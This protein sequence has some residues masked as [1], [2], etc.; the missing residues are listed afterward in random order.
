LEELN[1]YT[2]KDF[3]IKGHKTIIKSP[4][5]INECVEAF[6]IPPMN[7][8]DYAKCVIFANLLTW[9]QLHS[10][11]REKGGAY[12]AGASPNESGL[13]ML[14]SFRDPNPKRTFNCFEKSIIKISKGE[15]TEDDIRDAKIFTFQQTDKIINPLNKGL[16]SFLR[17]ITDEDRNIYRQKLLNVTREVKFNI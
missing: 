11:I 2:L 5:Q 14:Y 7:H 3:E 13:V 1:D 17:N 15:F 16:L 8:E 6:I 4:S 12:G 9:S 10:E